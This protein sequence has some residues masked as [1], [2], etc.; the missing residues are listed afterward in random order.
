META[1]SVSSKDAKLNVEQ[2]VHSVRNVLN[3]HE[4]RH[5]SMKEKWHRSQENHLKVQKIVR[6]VEEVIHSVTKVHENL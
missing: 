2:S 4:Q 6:I 5:L 1:R 3:E